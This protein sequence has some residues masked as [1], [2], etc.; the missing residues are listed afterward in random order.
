MSSRR[1]V[2]MDCTET[3]TVLTGARRR[4]HQLP[5]IICTDAGYD[6]DDMAALVVAVVT[7][8]VALVITSDEFGGGQRARMVRYWLDLCGL[9][10]ITVAAGAEIAGAEARWVCDGLVPPG[11]PRESSRISR[12]VVGEVRHILSGAGEAIW[13]GQGPMTNLAAVYAEAP[14]LARRL[15]VV[16]MGGGFAHLYRRPDRASHN[17]RMDPVSARKVLTASGLSLD[18]V[19]SDVTFTAENAIHAGSEEY[20]LLAAANAPKWARLV[21]AGFERWFA[22]KE[23][24]SKAADPLTVSVAAGMGFVRFAQALVEIGEDARMSANPG[25]IAIRMSVAADYGQ[26][27]AWMCGVIQHALDSGIRYDPA[28]LAN[29]RMDRDA[30]EGLSPQLE[31]RS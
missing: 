1:D 2:S 26:F 6:P 13:I 4:R 16:Q 30:G 10:H 19:T 17:L 31:V 20:A 9:P 29:H 27:R 22:L 5:A 28:L 25:G 3:A 8:P 23:P 11:F 21:A 7:L 15:T 24:E 14:E 18:L 12:S